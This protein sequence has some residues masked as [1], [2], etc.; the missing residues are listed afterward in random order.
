[1]TFKD[2]CPRNERA[3]DKKVAALK[4][5]RDL[6]GRLAILASK[7]KLDLQHVFSY[8]LTPVPLS[9]CYGDGTMA[10]T[11]KSTLLKI[12]ENRVPRSSHQTIDAVI[13]D[14]NFLLH[15]LPANQPP[16]YGGLATALGT[17]S[18]M[19]PFEY[20]ASWA[21]LVRARPL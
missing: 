7:R 8:P 2:E 14:G 5:T 21:R 11:Q 3:A 15:A 10:K 4:C 9:M 20:R 6:M 13:I 19:G 16:T 1:M 18:R 17:K 12:L